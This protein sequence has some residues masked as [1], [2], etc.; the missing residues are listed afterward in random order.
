[1]TIFAS[2]PYASKLAAVFFILFYFILFTFATVSCVHKPYRSASNS[3]WPSRWGSIGEPR[4]RPLRKRCMKTIWKTWADGA[5]AGLILPLWIGT[6]ASTGVVQAPNQ[7]IL[8]HRMHHL[9]EVR[10]TQFV[11]AR[12]LWLRLV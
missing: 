8:V 4:W 1:M 7:S 6:Y 11:R 9:Q 10:S 3:I 2:I 12:C 5:G